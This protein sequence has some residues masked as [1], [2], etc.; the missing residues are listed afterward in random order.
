MKAYQ[1]QNQVDIA[2]ALLAQHTIPKVVTTLCEDY[3]LSERTAYRRVQEA[4]SGEEHV[5]NPSKQKGTKGESAVV[6]AARA[7]EFPDAERLALAGAHDM[8]DVR[9]CRSVVVEVKS[10]KAAEQASVQLIEDWLHESETERVNANAD[11]CLLVTKKAGKGYDN[12][13]TWNGWM[14]FRDYLAL[15]LS[16]NGRRSSDEMAEYFDGSMSAAIVH[17]SFA[18]YLLLFR[19]AGYPDAVSSEPMHL[20]R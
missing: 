12:A 9:L 14:Y 13:H 1:I 5:A 20:V 4:Q 19:H 10:G 7:H 18:D 17:M 15:S 11:F 6:K 16:T 3:D 2:K 8:G